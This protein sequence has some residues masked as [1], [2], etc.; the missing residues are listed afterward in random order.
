MTH[1]I[2][3]WV[4]GA[5][6]ADGRSL[7]RDASRLEAW[8]AEA[9]TFVS[10]LDDASAR[11]RFRDGVRA[12]HGRFIRAYRDA[13]ADHLEMQAIDRLSS[14][15]AAVADLAPALLARPD[16]LAADASRPLETKIG[17]EYKLA[18]LYAELL[19]APRTG[20]LLV[21][22]A[23]RETSR[24]PGELQR[25]HAQDELDLESARMRRDGPVATIEITR[26]ERLNAE[27]DALLDALEVC[28]DVALLDERI[29]IVVLRGGRVSHPKY[30]GRRVFCSGIDLTDIYEGRLSHAYYVRRELGLVSKIYRGLSA[31]ADR[32]EIE[33]LF[34]AA[35]DGHAIG[36]GLQLLLVT[37]YVV[38]DD[39]AVLQLPA[40]REGI[41]PGA[42]NLRLPRIIG[43]RPARRALL[44][45]GTIP[46]ASAEGQLLVD[47]A[48]PAA[49][50]D[51]AVDA[52]VS[53]MI[54]AG[55][56]SLAAN[57]KAL[58]L[59]QE[60]IETFR[61]YMA[62]FSLAQADCH[63]SPALVANLKNHWISRQRPQPG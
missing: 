12:A 41:I 36:G 46:V 57:R 40:R 10:R 62:H 51:G 42:A 32:P 9:A 44:L 25:F 38:A 60:P 24:S 23:R 30:A 17:F 56:V 2:A 58:R 27:N 55:V 8:H 54:D 21:E 33:K 1:P 39:R 34:V 22:C 45:G 3:A 19:G 48:H 37:D 31:T 4:A 11:R 20:D 59:G 26:P 47:E 16:E 6:A 50:L 28:V 7:A 53:A 35:V 61:A 5:P 13:I 63:F 14:V 29:E 18:V 15:E 52:A 43:E 49:S